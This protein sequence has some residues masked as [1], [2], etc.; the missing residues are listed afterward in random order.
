MSL[1]RRGVDARSESPDFT[2]L[3][4]QQRF[5]GTFSD[6]GNTISG[7]WEKGLGG[8][9]LGARLRPYLPPGRLT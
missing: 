8:A 6:D 4:F 3:D 5:T 2:P 1:A 7:A 9:R